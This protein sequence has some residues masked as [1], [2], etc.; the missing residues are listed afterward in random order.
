MRRL[1]RTSPRRR[2]RPSP[3]GWSCVMSPPPIIGANDISM[4]PGGV[5]GRG[6]A[7]SGSA[8]R[9][10]RENSIGAGKPG[11][12]AAQDVPTPAAGPALGR[13]R[14]RS[15]RC[16]HGAAV[17]AVALLRRGAWAA[18]ALVGG[19]LIS[20]TLGGACGVGA[21]GGGL[22]RC[23]AGGF[24]RGGAVSC[25]GGVVCGGGAAS[26][27]GGTS[28]AP[29]PSALLVGRFL[30]R[31]HGLLR[32]RHD[33]RQRRGFGLWRR[34]RL[35]RLHTVAAAA[36]GPAPMDAAPARPAGSATTAR[37]WQSRAGSCR[38]SRTPWPWETAA[39][40]PAAG[41]CAAPRRSP[42]PTGPRAAGR[43]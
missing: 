38:H 39:P 24:L 35:L 10:P 41:A 25:F 22:F 20:G 28:P 8:T 9:G 2:P 29:A 11:R 30:G 13:R 19:A 6:G 32:L 5:R 4:L 16:R 23:C 43:R 37:D 40:P 31:R 7:A 36:A 26:C 17:A 42:A 18:G 14:R 33:P 15:L 3:S 34:R 1:G 12:D 21:G 27:S